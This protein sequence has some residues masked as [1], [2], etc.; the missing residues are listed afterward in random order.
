MRETQTNL[1]GDLLLNLGQPGDGPLHERVKRALRAAIRQGRIEIGTAL[2][3][4]RSSPP[5]SAVHGGR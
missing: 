5:I 3:P 4:S 1:A 2:P